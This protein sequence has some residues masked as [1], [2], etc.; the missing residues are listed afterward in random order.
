ME[1]I[2]RSCVI[3]ERAVYKNGEKIFSA[4]PDLWSAL[5]QHFNWQYPKYFKMDNLSKLGWAAAEVL[6]EG[7]NSTCNPEEIAVVLSNANSS[8][9]TDYRY[10]ATTKDIPSP[11][12]FVYTLPN[13]VIGEICIRHRFKGENAFFLSEAF[14][15][16]LLVSYVSLLLRQDIARACITGWVELLGDSFKAALFLIEQVTTADAL[17]LSAE[18]MDNLFKNST[19]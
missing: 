9:D 5:Y 13:I 10:T 17:S 3:T 1:Y 4:T 6:L 7:W 2:T 19:H 14:D 11:S 16:R 18:N 12:V 15:A 8:L